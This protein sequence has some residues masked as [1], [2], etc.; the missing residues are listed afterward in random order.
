[1]EIVGLDYDYAQAAIEGRV[2]VPPAGISVFNNPNPTPDDL[3]Y[4]AATRAYFTGLAEEQRQ[5]NP[6][7][8]AA[9]L[10]Q[11]DADMR[12]RLPLWQWEIIDAN[13]ADLVGRGVIKE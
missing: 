5:G 3:A 10:A 13:H 6:T 7:R 11:N 9:Q 12:S 2:V 8:L 1:M 4:M